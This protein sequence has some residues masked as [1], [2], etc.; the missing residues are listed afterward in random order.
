MN[1]R[2]TLAAASLAVMAAAAMAGAAA[3]ACT[4]S[5]EVG[6]TPDAG[7]AGSR[8]TVTGL[9]FES[10]TPVEIRWGTR[11]GPLL[12]T[13]TGPN[14]AVEVTIPAGAAAG[15]YVIVAMNVDGSF[16][17]ATPFQVT[18]SGSASTTTKGTSGSRTGSV[19]GG[20]GQ[21]SPATAGPEE[22]GGPAPATS[23]PVEV[24]PPRY[25]STGDGE[26]SPA[27]SSPA[28]ASS[29]AST[30]RG[31]Q[32]GRTRGPVG[33]SSPSGAATGRPLGTERRPAAPAQV[34]GQQAAPVDVP[35]PRS[36]GSDVWGGFATGDVPLSG[37]GLATDVRSPG[38]GTSGLPVGVGL[39]SLGSL[40]LTAGAGV[41]LLGRR[42]AAAR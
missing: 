28:G 42:R 41:S 1:A 5:A 6:A 29:D 40:A 39:L 15:D 20:G 14:F 2:R 22:T 8:T 31:A 34:D 37:P 13:T 7:P 25:A 24:A 4:A 33:A 32:A 9:R 23:E 27:P 26:A 18:S 30:S 11:S 3:W 38:G 17:P 19:S 10:G 21:T 36:A 12:E 35:S 16:A